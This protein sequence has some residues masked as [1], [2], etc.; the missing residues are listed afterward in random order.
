MT[1]TLCCCTACC[2]F[3]TPIRCGT[4]LQISHGIAGAIPSRAGGDNARGQSNESAAT[5]SRESLPNTP[6]VN[7][8]TRGVEPPVDLTPNFR[9]AAA[10]AGWDD[11]SL[12][13]AAIGL[14]SPV[15][16]LKRATGKNT[17]EDPSTASCSGRCGGCNLCRERKRLI[18][19]PGQA[20]TPSS[21]ARR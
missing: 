10:M 20:A 19:T 1:S 17:P 9:F 6:K 4:I 5:S 11:E 7:R 18:R 21:A 12:L 13:L 3:L 14:D 8:T 16:V 2:C 15:E